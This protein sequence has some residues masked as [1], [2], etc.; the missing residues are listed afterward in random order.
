MTP[1]TQDFPTNAF[2]GPLDDHGRIPAYQQTRVSAFLMSAHGALA[3]QLA[4]LLPASLQNGF[5][6]EMHAECCRQIEFLSLLTRAT[7]W[8]PD[9]MLPFLFWQWESAW[10]PQ[11]VDWVDDWMQGRL[12]DLAAFNHALHAVIRPAALLPETIDA[13]DP[14]VQA[15]RHIEF[16]SG[17]LMQAQILY[18]KSPQFSSVRDQVAAAVERRHDQVRE[19]LLSMLLELQIDPTGRHLVPTAYHL[20]AKA[21]FD[22]AIAAATAAASQEAKQS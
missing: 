10:W 22:A 5:Q 14:F 13:T 15:L 21:A 16:E 9:P 20:T 6:V 3:R 18:L 2:L 8:V 7:T 11:P 4:A 19:L 1:A 17:R 12:I